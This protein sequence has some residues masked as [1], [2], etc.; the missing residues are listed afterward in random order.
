MVAKLMVLFAVAAGA[1]GL[2]EAVEAFEA[3]IAVG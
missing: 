2:E 3:G 1:G